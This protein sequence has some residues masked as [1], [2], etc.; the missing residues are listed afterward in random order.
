M[1]RAGGG[2]EQFRS[3]LASACTA[4]PMM[5][6]RT[7]AITHLRVGQQN[8][9]GKIPGAQS[10]CLKVG[11]LLV[12]NWRYERLCLFRAVSSL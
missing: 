9:S 7:E 4:T 5:D 11:D 2:D 1:L 6:P 10:G 12:T 3:A 8:E